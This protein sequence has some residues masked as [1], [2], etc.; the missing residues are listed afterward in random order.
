MAPDANPARPADDDARFAEISEALADAVEAAVA[1]WIVRLVT[2]RMREHGGEAGPD[3][4]AAAEQAGEAA[5]DDVMPQLRRLLRTDLDEQ[6]SNPLAVLRGATR[7]AHA[8]LA[9]AGVRPVV[10]DDFSERSFPDD[11]YGLVPATWEDIDPGLREIGITWGAAKAH[12]FK[13]RR[14][15]EGRT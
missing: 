7:H 15:A 10:R 1:P 2:Q 13:A 4:L 6:R 9:A 12:V 5:R 3:V 11:T 14:R 8:V